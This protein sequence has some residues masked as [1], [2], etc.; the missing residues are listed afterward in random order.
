MKYNIIILAAL[1]FSTRLHGQ[2]P[3]IDTGVIN[4]W[5]F[6]DLPIL[7]DDGKYASFLIRN[8]P[9]NSFTL[10]VK[11]VN[12]DWHVGLPSADRGQFAAD[13]KH[14]IFRLENDTMGILTLGTNSTRL[15]SNVV[16]AM[17][18]NNANSPI[19]AYR[20]AGLTPCLHI[21]YLISKKQFE[22]FGITNFAVSPDGRVLLFETKDSISNTGQ[23]TL[24]WWDVLKQTDR[25]IYSGG[26]TSEYTFDKTGSALAFLS[27]DT[28]GIKPAI[29]YWKGN[30]Q[31]IKIGMDS[32]FNLPDGI[33]LEN[34]RGFDPEGT[35]IYFEYS[36]KPA[37]ATKNQNGVKVDV[38]NYKDA[39]LQS[40]Q[41]YEKSNPNDPFT[42]AQLLAV[43]ILNPR[44]IIPL[45]G[46]AERVDFP[47]DNKIVYG[48]WMVV[49]RSPGGE[50]FEGYWNKEAID[51]F[52]LVSLKSGEHVPLPISNQFNTSLVLISPH[53][54][55]IVYYDSQKGDYFSYSIAHRFLQNI[56]SSM[57]IIWARGDDGHPSRKG[58]I[59]GIA[60]WSKDGGSVYLYDKFDIWKISLDGSKSPVNL[61]NF[62]GQRKGIELR[63]ADR[64]SAI[65]DDHVS[66][67]GFNRITKDQGF[68][69]LSTGSPNDPTELTFGPYFY[70]EYDG[71]NNHYFSPLKAK[72]ANAYIVRRMTAEES[73][74][75]FYT[76]DF[77]SFQPISAVYPEK[78]VNWIK[79]ELV[80]WLAP[81][82]DSLQGLLYKPE[83]FDPSR[84]YPIIFTYY[85][86]VSEC[87][88]AFIQPEILNGKI[89][90]PWFVSNGYLVFEPDIY[91]KTGS[92]GPSALNAVLS[93]AKYLS[94]RPWIDTTKMAIQGMS[95][96]GYET[97][98]IVTHSHLFAAA[99]SASGP[100]DF[101]SGYG[102]LW[103]SG[104]SCQPL[105]EFGQSRMGQSLWDN[106]NG[107]INNSPIFF[108]N[109]VTTPLLMLNNKADD[110]VP[111]QHG[112]E[113][114]TALRRL[115]KKAW[116]LQYDDGG[117]GVT[118]NSNDAVDYSIRVFQFFDFYLKDSLPPVWMT[119]GILAVDKEIKTGLE[120]DT[121]G[122]LP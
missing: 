79:S 96:G 32:S 61:T 80:N 106:P 72:H 15:I 47:D 77:K 100:T 54:D 63:L 67:I 36:E 98:Y 31:E 12:S 81:L 10:T 83:N 66:L 29:W 16:S 86:Q 52:F 94:A 114:F 64:R 11:D 116:M 3:L 40:L 57:P 43:V 84:K 42:R 113:F 56:T 9:F 8:D 4:K 82:G 27:K 60:G 93:A 102:S 117:H 37:Q 58:L 105:Y 110:A 78:R 53:S 2:K 120:L 35:T 115:G 6:V 118:K 38:W 99:M 18:G 25:I 46:Q 23:F 107:Y 87:L 22:K 39:K 48:S 7:S 88:N 21:E 50:A 71:F 97:N 20:R 24:H 73:S 45:V 92:P 104:R 34:I 95:W 74:N 13:N 30:L 122:A 17:V 33:T 76:L 111:F 55:F 62:Y 91:Y 70:G 119:K 75:F 90:I 68:F 5:T 109:Q 85:E 89:N 112:L 41:I 19:L 69:D 101:V 121:S 65:L 51:S 1:I 59:Y 14:F 108:A 44:K 103:H 28:A 49:R 26:M